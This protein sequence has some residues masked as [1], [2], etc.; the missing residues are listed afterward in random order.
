MTIQDAAAVA[1]NAVQAEI[2]DLLAAK[3]Y[4][5]GLMLKR[6]K[7]VSGGDLIRMALNVL[8]TPTNGFI[9]GTTDTVSINQAQNLT[10]G[11]LNW[12]Y[13]Y[14]NYTL[15]LDDMTKTGDTDKAIIDLVKAKAASSKNSAV[16]TLSAAMYGSGSSDT[17]VF[18]GFAD[19]FAASGT[20]YA[21][22]LDTVY[23]SWLPVYNSSDTTPTYAVI[24]K[25]MGELSEKIQQAPIDNE[26][27][28]EYEL[29]VM[30]SRAAVQDYYKTTLQNQQRF[31][32]IETVKSGFK[33]VS[34][35]GV[36]WYTDSFCPGSVNG[37]TADNYLYL[38][39]SSSFHLFYKYG[40]GK[41]N[42][43]LDTKQ[44]LPNQPV[45]INTSYYA[46]NLGCSN[47]R[48]NGAFKTLQV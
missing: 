31:A 30:I 45:N 20:A 37:S 29:D 12:K 14:Q 2:P 38:L 6:A 11:T 18:N 33:G 36:F 25:M 9:N 4:L 19:I 21:N 41:N 48:V 1:V 13:F 23:P 47:R 3:N 42:C 27:Q 7:Y 44:T 32:D 46:G 35:N 24:S 34:V 22:V 40:F 8:E 26:L 10:Y 43:P 5:Y 15:S 17:N 39:S 28:T 16:R